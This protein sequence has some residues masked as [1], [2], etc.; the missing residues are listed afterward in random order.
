MNPTK[1]ALLVGLFFLVLYAVTVTVV[2][3]AFGW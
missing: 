3:T 2:F 1:T